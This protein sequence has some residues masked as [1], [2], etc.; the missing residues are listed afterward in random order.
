MSETMDVLIVG[1][2]PAGMAAAIEL[3]RYGV[4]FA[5]IDENPRPGGQVYRQPPAEFES[6]G[7][8]TLS[9][10]GYGEGRHLVQAFEAIRNSCRIYHDTYVW[11]EFNGDTLAFVSNGKIFRV[12]YRKLLICEGAMERLTPFPGWTLP[13]VMTLGGVK[14]LFTQDGCRLGVRVLLAGRSPLLLSVAAAVASAGIKVVAVADALPLGAYAGLSLQLMKRKNP[15]LEAIDTCFKVW[16]SG[17]PMLRSSTVTS[18]SGDSRLESVQIARIDARGNPVS[19]SVKNFKADI[20]GVSDGFLPSARM[21]RLLGCKHHWD[22]LECC[23]Q[24]T[25]ADG[26]K[27]SLENVYIAGDSA[28]IAGREAAA[29]RG[30]LAAASIAASLDRLPSS[31]GRDRIRELEN[32]HGRI[33]KYANALTRTFSQGPEGCAAMDP[34]TIV[35]RCEQVRV[36]DVI[37]GISKGYRNINEIKRTRVGMGLCQGRTCEWVTARIM[38]NHGIPVEEIGYFNLRPPLAPIPFSNFEAYAQAEAAHPSKEEI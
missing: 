28:G 12:K 19:G 32:E 2:G 15:A 37:D 1:M 11:G 22:A 18:V 7:R 10:P 25:V 14:K 31:K 8:D 29:V 13:G 21:A 5:I 35:C 20:L 4:Q 26:C 3:H 38:L 6:C 24:P 27:T 36:G 23:W 30:R 9:H 34:D 17:I 16:R 33:M